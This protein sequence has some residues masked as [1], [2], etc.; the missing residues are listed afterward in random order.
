MLRTTS[1]RWAALHASKM[2]QS[3]T[4][5]RLPPTSPTWS[6]VTIFVLALVLLYCDRPIILA[7]VPTSIAPT[8]GTADLGTTVTHTGHTVQ[9]TGGTRPDNG[10]NLFHSFDQFNVGRSDTAQFLNTTPA[11]HTANILS[12][13]TGE[14]PSSIFGTI[15]TMS[16]PGA[17]LFLMNPAGIVFGPNA[18]LN[19]A[20]SVTF[21]TAHYLRLADNG[22]F[23]AIPN[24]TADTLLSTAPVAT[25]GFLGSN[26]GTIA[27]Q[28]SRF[29]VPKGDSIALVGGG[30]TVQSGTLNNSTVQS[31]H[32]AAPGGRIDLVSVA[33]PGEITA[34]SL[35][36]VPNVN[37]RSFEA[38]GTIQISQQ[39]TIDTSGAGGG[40]VHI[41]GGRLI[42]DNSVISANTVATN[43]GSYTGPFGKGIDIHVA[44][45]ATIQN[46]SILETNVIGPVA[47]NHGSGGVRISARDITISGGPDLLTKAQ[48]SSDGSFPFS[49][50]RSNIEP[51]STAGRSGDITLEANSIH[52]QDLGQVQT[53]TVGQGSAGQISLKAVGAIDLNTAIVSSESKHS[54][55]HAGNIL[56]NSSQGDIHLTTSFLTS[57]TVDSSGNAGAITLTAPLGDIVLTQTSQVLN[58]TR[59]T[60]VLGGIQVSA[61]NL[62][63]QGESRIDGDNFSTRVA[64][65]IS[66]VLNNRLSLTEQSAIETAT[67]GST[68]AA[69][70]VIKASDILIAQGSRLFTGTTGSGAGGAIHLSARTLAIQDSGKISAETSGIA[71]S[72]TGGSITVNATDQVSLTNG[73]SITSS[74]IV[75]PQI[76]SSGIANAGHISIN[77]GQQ[78]EVTTGSSIT[79]TTQSP[80]ANGGN[81]TIQAIDQVRFVDSTLSTSV[82]G[83]EGSGG[84][85]FIDPKVVVLQGSDVT[86][87]AVGGAGGN[88]TFV[89]PLFLTDSA[90]VVSASSQRGPSGTVTIQSPTSNLSGAVGQ[91]VSKITPTQILI[92][93]RCVSST[94]GAQSTFILAGRES[95]PAEPGGWLSSPISMEHW[96]GEN[97][98]HAS[99][100]IV[101]NRGS[102]SSPTLARQKDNATVLSLRR[103]T[104]P[105]YLVRAFASGS[106]DCS[107]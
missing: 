107:S 47:S 27:V 23:H 9:I 4:H 10:V 15:D 36:S 18:T 49:G 66:L 91:L 12:R 88:I 41:R 63:L 79:T 96:T 61:N 56:F 70:L 38:L 16:Y 17:N 1:K 45:D 21:T 101:R 50:I 94:P 73:A 20:G 105:G 87:Q 25:Y 78:L 55:G 93:N 44:Q 5:N 98:E 100:L 104:P 13:V 42:I 3:G 80:Q 86:A 95:L 24:M 102:K 37:G 85:I 74:S 64:E 69:H 83:I 68:N 92:Q 48:T 30:I 62:Q 97:T 34:Q 52:V 67:S 39:S 75:T 106:T 59:G 60:G 29:A 6:V 71:S 2:R 90:S 76:P 7:Q 40:T 8:A 82:R 58:A 77:A 43:A 103:L 31:V 35:D 22:R 19:V 54:S 81:I 51:K 99:G 33:S 46:K 28:G 72:A 14:T 53:Q 32:L 26:P 11:L 89:T 57:Q 84:N 65:N